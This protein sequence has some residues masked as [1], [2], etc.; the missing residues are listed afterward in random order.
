MRSI[1]PSACDCWRNARCRV[2]KILGHD[3]ACPSSPWL[4]PDVIARQ[5]RSLSHGRLI[6]MRR[7]YF[8]VDLELVMHHAIETEL[9]A[10]ELQTVAR[11]LS[12]ELSILQR[13]EEHTSELQSRGHL[14][15][16][17]LLEKKKE[18]CVSMK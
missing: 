6:P 5:W 15:C 13:S 18:K 4:I 7:Y 14:V 9:F 16:R 12:G 11:A 10:R 8:S 2:P 1:A 3:S 17:L